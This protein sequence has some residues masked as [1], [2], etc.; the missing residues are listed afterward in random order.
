MVTP[1]LFLAVVKATGAE[2]VNVVVITVVFI[3]G[4]SIIFSEVVETLYLICVV[5]SGCKV[6]GLVT[7]NETDVVFNGGAVVIV[8]IIGNLTVEEVLV[9]ES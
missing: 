6:N 4:F 2:V 5:V 1:C 7:R 3:F 9:V 8:L